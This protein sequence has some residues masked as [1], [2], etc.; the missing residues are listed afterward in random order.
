MG[1]R[2]K[3]PDALQFFHSLFQFLFLEFIGSYFLLFG[4]CTPWSACR[5]ATHT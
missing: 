1:K 3:T 2:K 4:Q 5:L